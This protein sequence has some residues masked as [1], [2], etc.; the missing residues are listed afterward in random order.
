MKFQS[1]TLQNFH[2]LGISHRNTPA[3]IREQ[4]SLSKEQMAKLYAAAREQGINS[5]FA[6]STCN[7]TE[8]YAITERPEIIIDLLEVASFELRVTSENNPQPAT[9]NSQLIQQ[10]ATR[11]SQLQQY[12]YTK[13]S[14]EAILHLMRVASGLDAQILGDAQITG[15]IREFHQLAS[16]HTALDATLNRLIEQSISTGKKVKTET[17]HNAGASTI[18]HAAVSH[19]LKQVQQRNFRALVLGAGKTGRLVVK[20][21]L[22]SIHAKN[23]TVTNRTDATAT[24]LAQE[25]SVQAAEYGRLKNAIANADAIF[26]AT[27]SQQ[28]IITNELLQGVSL[29]GKLF[30]DLSLPRNIEPSLA[31]TVVSIDQLTD[32]NTQ[33]REQYTQIA[34]QHIA[35]G[36]KEYQEWLSRYELAQDVK[37]HIAQSI[38]D[39]GLDDDESSVPSKFVDRI[40]SKHLKHFQ[41]GKQS[42][43][44]A[45]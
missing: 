15:Q 14:D 2:I 30:I 25:L 19:A 23:I 4:F 1:D 5:I 28:A 34:E 8:I 12:R 24:E 43:N 35:A 16:E 10:P 31:A 3:E 44:L 13:A 17:Q 26:A 29:D 40:A 38:F 45:A 36:I 6:I 22:K 32:S 7:R 42:R 39:N 20:S 33:Q 18:A 9:R 37:S 21:L 27:A 41:K 11:N